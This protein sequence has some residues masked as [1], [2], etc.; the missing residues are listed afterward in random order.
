MR[1]PLL[2]GKTTRRGEECLQVQFQT[3][4][5]SKIEDFYG[6]VAAEEIFEVHFYRAAWPTDS[7]YVHFYVGYIV[8]CTIQYRFV[9]SSG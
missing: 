8:Q 2:V 3:F 1:L 7:C 6:R 9:V 4:I 5:P